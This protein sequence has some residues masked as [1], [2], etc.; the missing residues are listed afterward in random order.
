[1]R[2]LPLSSSSIVE[3]VKILKSG[4]VV[5][6]PTDTLYGLGADATN[7]DAVERIYTIKGRD[8]Q[9]PLSV[10]VGNRA[11]A[12]RLVK[13]GGKE[14][15]IFD[16]FLPGAFTLI[17]LKRK[18]ALSPF[19]AKKV[20]GIGIRMPDDKTSKTI[21]RSLK[22]P[23]TSTSA[24]VSGEETPRSAKKI[25]KIFSRRREQPDL[26][27]DAGIL[28]NRK[29]SV[30]IDMSGKIPAIHRTNSTEKHIIDSFL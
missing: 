14:K 23:F 25:Y 3:A 6:Y 13:M 2:I 27:L 28:R 8:F 16:V 18:G 29:P 12:E 17:L 21:A 7:N 26:I 4:G 20:R 5:V 9:K 15:K 24:N 11:M 1:M 19:L 30:I 10:V 22:R